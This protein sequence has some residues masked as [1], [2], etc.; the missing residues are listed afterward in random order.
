MT[1][2]CDPLFSLLKKD[3]NIEWTESLFLD[4]DV[5]ALEPKPDSVELWHWSGSSLSFPQGPEIPVS[6]KLNFDCTNNI[7][8]YEACIVNL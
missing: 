7:I 8:E 4:E 6:V 5:M 1:S 3:I 2:T